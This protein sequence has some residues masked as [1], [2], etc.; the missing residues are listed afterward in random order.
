MP[1]INIICQP[2]GVGLSRDFDILDKLLRSAGYDTRLV[3]THKPPSQCKADANIFLERINS[4]LFKQSKRNII[5]PNQE[6]YEPDWRFV[7]PLFS[8]VFTKTSYASNIF[9]SYGG[10]V[11]EVGFTSPDLKNDNYEKDD[12]S[13]LHVAGKSIQK[14][15][16]LVIKAWTQHNTL[17][18]LTIVQTDRYYKPRVLPPNLTIRYGM[19]PQG[20]LTALQNTS[21]VHVCPSITEGFGH[22]IVEAMSCGSVVITMDGPPMNEIVTKDV[23]EL[24]TPVAEGNMR[25]S[26]TFITDEKSIQEACYRCMSLGKEKLI[27]MGNNSRNRYEKI[28][29]LF[30]KNFIEAIDSVIAG[31]IVSYFEGSSIGS[32]Q[33]KEKHE[34]TGMAPNSNKQEVLS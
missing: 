29:L 20:V 7:I 6:W 10:R 1:I 34:H 16:E 3:V 30:K 21:M 28:D 23:G 18:H 13:W 5:I 4:K 17:P 24:I 31:K 19:T 22:Y 8:A 2:N 14:Q 9:R 15:T 25:L 33:R 32:V 11:W 27:E 26:K 12:K